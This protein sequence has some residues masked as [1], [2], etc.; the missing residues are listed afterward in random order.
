MDFIVQYDRPGNALLSVNIGQCTNKSRKSP[1]LAQ[2][3]NDTGKTH[4]P[5]KQVTYG[6]TS[7]S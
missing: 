7:Y 6:D 5:H 4:Q 1:M 2:K 3:M